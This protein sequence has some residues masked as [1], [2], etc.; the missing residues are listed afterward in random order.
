MAA[1][2]SLSINGPAGILEAAVRRAKP[3]RAA[4]VVAHPH[5]LYGGTMHNPVVFHSERALHR[6]GLSTLRFNFRGVGASAGPH[7]DGRGEVEDFA[8]AVAALRRLAPDVPL[9]AVGYSFGA[10]CAIR[11]AARDA[12]IAGVVAI[13]LATRVHPLPEIERLARP[14]AVVQGSAD[15]LGPPAE[16]RARIERLVPPG[17]LHVIDGAPHLFP[18]RAAEVAAA[19]V[20]AARTLLD[21]GAKTAPPR[22]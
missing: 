17:I 11:Y 6:L 12:E 3:A 1:Q 8:A 10:A 9:L 2:S 5:P 13:G 19:V 14:L 16:V 21:G 15:E 18:G 20:A 22:S 7:D 4:A